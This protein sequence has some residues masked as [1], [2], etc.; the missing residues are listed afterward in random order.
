MAQAIIQQI[1]FMEDFK[2]MKN[3]KKKEFA[4]IAA[5]LLILAFLVNMSDIILAN[6][7]DG[8]KYLFRDFY[9][10]PANEVDVVY[11]GPS[12]AGWNW[13]PTVAYKSHGI[14]SQLLMSERHPAD[15]FPYLLK[16]AS[17]KKPKLYIIDAENLLGGFSD[18]FAA[19]QSIIIN[20]RHSKNRLDAANDM[21]E[22]YSDEEKSVRF[23]PLIYFHNRWKELSRSDFEPVN[24]DFMG[25]S[26][27]ALSGTGVPEG[28]GQ[29]EAEPIALSGEHLTNFEE[30]LRVCKS[31][32]GNVLFMIAPNNTGAGGYYNYIRERVEAEGFS[33]LNASGFLDEIGMEP[34]DFQGS[35]H[36][37][38]YGAE[39]YTE[40]LSGVLVEK[41]G[42]PDH[43]NE[44]DYK[45]SVRYEEEY[46]AY[47]KAKIQKGVMIGKYLESINSERYSIL[48]AVRDEAS[49]AL[50]EE[51]VH[52]LK[53]L[54]LQQTPAGKYR[55]SYIAVTDQGKLILEHITEAESGEMLQESGVLADGADFTLQS[56][57]GM[58]GNNA[59]IIVN[60]TE[61]AINSRGI[62][63]VVYDNVIHEVIDSVAF[64]TYAAEMPATREIIQD[65]H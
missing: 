40:W 23:L 63:I 62:N 3:Y 19:V 61:Y 39:K 9:N 35:G 48:M 38:I 57:G 11:I 6:G 36:L 28:S 53:Q 34:G 65:V 12:S 14:G 24:Y 18:D 49:S 26:M 58:A 22:H 51:I 50:N 31:L 33:Y 16:E 54:G 4:K 55:A 47:I 37:T 29:L 32:D 20:L 60:G 7:T 41:F 17:L 42:I 64:D 1:S 52:S 30:V 43:R 5:F 15:A 10:A 46:E 27:R 21:L 8:H 59:S 45:E 2:N 13:N 56:G 44:Q 25:F